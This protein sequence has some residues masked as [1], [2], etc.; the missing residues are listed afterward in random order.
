MKR[1][2]AFLFIALG[3]IGLGS[4]R[5]T[6]EPELPEDNPNPAEF[7][8]IVVYYS[9]TNNTKRIGDTIAD[10]LSLPVFELVP[11]EPYS[12]EDLN[13]NYAESR[14]CREHN[15]PNRH[16]ALVST[17]IEG[18][19]NYTYVFIGYPIWWS[20]ASWVLDDFVKNNDFTGKTVIPF[21]TSASSPLGNSAKNLAAKA[22]SGVWNDGIRF[23]SSASASEITLWIDSLNLK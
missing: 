8:G 21:A 18:F 6:E 9:A 17:A 11:E 10:Y 14:V 7:Q 16:T 22:G 3:L 13:Y 19:E 2:I 1:I 12:S 20:E 4:C 23:R 15:D 5:K